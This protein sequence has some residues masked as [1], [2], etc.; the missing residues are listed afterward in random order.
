MTELFGISSQGLPII[1]HPFGREGPVVLILG[2][3]HGDEPEGNW[4][5][6]G[7]LQK[8]KK[9]FPYKLR[10][11][12]VPCFNIE[13]SLSHERTNFN[14]VEFKPQPS[15]KKLDEQTKRICFRII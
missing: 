11:T 3:V 6:F 15:N 8:W 5:A 7:L 13:G 10:L 4:I 2:G 14:K 9:E 1:C 12:L